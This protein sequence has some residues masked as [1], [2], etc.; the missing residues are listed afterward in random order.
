MVEMAVDDEY[1]TKGKNKVEYQWYQARSV[2]G[3]VY[4]WRRIR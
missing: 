3:H 1:K 4:S 2:D